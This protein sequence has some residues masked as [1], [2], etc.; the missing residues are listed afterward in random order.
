MNAQQKDQ[1]L[2]LQIGRAIEPTRAGLPNGARFDLS[3]GWVE[4]ARTLRRAQLTLHRWA[5]EMCNGTI[6]RHEDHKDPRD[7]NSN[8][9]PFRHYLSGHY[10]Q[11]PDRERGALARVEAVCKATGLHYYHQTDP[12]GCALYVAAE[13]LN[14]QNYSTRGVACL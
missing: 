11:C 8:G 7:P 13:P 9:L 10:V 12:R 14:S 3:P 1:T 5:E 2:A 6:R 4:H